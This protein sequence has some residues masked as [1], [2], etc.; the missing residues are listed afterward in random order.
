MGTPLYMSPEQVEGRSVDSR[1]DLYSLGATCYHLLAG[2]PPHQGE[3]ALAIAVQHLNAAPRPLENIRADVPSGL[4]RV[5]HRLL[6]KKPEHR[7]QGAHELLA[8]LRR[9]AGEAAAEGWG[10]GAEHWS[11]ANVLAADAPSQS[12]AELKR[13]M[14][15]S[16]KLDERTSN[17][18]YLGPVIAAALV[19]GAGV[20]FLTRP[21]SYLAGDPVTRVDRRDSALAQLYHAKTS[22]SEAAW[23]AVMQF[24]PNADRYELDLA[25]EGLA[26]YYLFDTE[27]DAKA[28]PVLEQLAESPDAVAADSPMR[29]FA[30]AGLYIARQRLGQTAAAN[31]AAEHIT[32]EMS[33]QLQ[34]TDAAMYQ[35]LQSVRQPQ[36][37]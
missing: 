16:T 29:A 12:A 31:V 5:V 32:S 21:E 9:L 19:L 17:R 4:A 27:E 25:R 15:V 35:L 22:P 6:A 37:T 28:I 33:E 1:S 26:R 7:Y 13:L 18:R 14:T 23:L 10:D 11:L 36:R 34:R 3:T 24:H 2:E 20:G 8:D 30:Y